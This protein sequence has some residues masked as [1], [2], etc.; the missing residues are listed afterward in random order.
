MKKWKKW[1]KVC[2]CTI[3]LVQIC[4][5]GHTMNKRQVYNI[6]TASLLVPE[7]VCKTSKR[8]R[9]ST[10]MYVHVG[11]RTVIG[12]KH[13]A[14]TFM[15]M[16]AQRFKGIKL[17]H[18]TFLCTKDFLVLNF[19]N[20]QYVSGERAFLVFLLNYSILYFCLPLYTLDYKEPT[21]FEA[22]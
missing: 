14:V 13:A 21:C 15:F 4:S 8:E 12:Y 6:Q 5:A 7:Y 20:V 3:G 9:E 18:I 1:K 17:C 19:Y 11:L 2:N 22:F 10:K 16:Y